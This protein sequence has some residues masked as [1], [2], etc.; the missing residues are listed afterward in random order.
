MEHPS[1]EL[2]PP[3]YS[4]SVEGPP[5]TYSTGGVKIRDPKKGDDDDNDGGGGQYTALPSPP[6]FISAPQNGNPEPNSNNY[7]GEVLVLPEAPIAQAHVSLPAAP[8][9][10]ANI[11]PVIAV[12]TPQGAPGYDDLAA[13]FAALS[14]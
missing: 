4:G 8:G 3:P 13:R 6:A 11:P 10:V 12:A 9:D 2:P 7:G 1:A 14:K 5:P